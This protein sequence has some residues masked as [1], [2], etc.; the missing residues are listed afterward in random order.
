MS[1]SKLERTTGGL[2]GME[3]SYLGR[4]QILYVELDAGYPNMQSE[5]L[6]G[7]P[8]NGI[9]LCRSLAQRGAVASQGNNRHRE[10]LV[11]L[12]KILDTTTAPPATAGEL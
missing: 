9:P 5:W 7:I 4:P 11:L 2:K 6:N 1:S 3:A 12:E 10:S 8:F